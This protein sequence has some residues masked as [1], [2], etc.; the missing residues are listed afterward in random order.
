M[1]FKGSLTGEPNGKSWLV[2]NCFWVSDG[3]AERDTKIP[4][5]GEK[6]TGKPIK[7]RKLEKK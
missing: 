6:K 1:A 4:F 7:P 5:R 2:F 3:I